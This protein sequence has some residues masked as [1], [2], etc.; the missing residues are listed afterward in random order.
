MS[1]EKARRGRPLGSC[2]DD[3]ALLSRVA[4][5]LVQNQMMKPTTAIK[6]VL[7]RPDPSPIRRLQSKWRACGTEYS[8]KAHLR[9]TLRLN[10]AKDRAMVEM[11]GQLSEYF[12]GVGRTS[13]H[14]EKRLYQEITT[15]KKIASDAS[16]ATQSAFG[17]WNKGAVSDILKLQKLLSGNAEAVAAANAMIEAQRIQSQIAAMTVGLYK[18][19]LTAR[20]LG[21]DS[22]LTASLL[23]SN[24]M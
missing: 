8:Q 1:I 3:S 9:A 10:E 15:A 6:R 22:S 12:S 14:I 4:D 16:I 23:R 19:P 11:Q 20:V 17:L 5:I 13:S 2:I 18:N 21:C 24:K 7:G